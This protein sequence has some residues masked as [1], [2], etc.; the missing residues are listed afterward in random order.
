MG[1]SKA[2]MQANPP[3]LP[4]FLMLQG[5]H[6]PFFDRLNAR[7]RAIG[8]RTCRIGFNLGDRAFWTDPKSFTRYF[9][10]LEDWPDYLTDL[11]ETN[12]ITD[13]VLYGD[14]RPVHK[15]AIEIATERGIPVHVFEEGY[16]R[17]YWITYERGGSNGH[18]RLAEMTIAEMQ[19]TLEAVR[20][21]AIVPPAKWGDMSAHV[22]YGAIYHAFV[23]AGLGRYRAIPSHRGITVRR[24]F[25]LYLQRLGLMP[26]HWVR[27][28]IAT[29]R[30]RDGGFP[31]HLVLLQLA[32][33]ANFLHHGPFH[34]MEDFLE[35]VIHG[36][37]AGAPANHHLVFKAHP[38]E[39][40]RDQI[41]ANVKRL[42]AVYDISARVHYVGGGKL[43][44]VLDPAESAV[45][46]NSTAAQQVLWRGL[47][48]KAFGA[49][50]YAKPELVS[51]QPIAGFFANPKRPDAG[52]YRD[53]HHYLLETS[54]IPGGFYSTRGRA[55][56]LRRI[57]DM[58]LS[59]TDPYDAL[60][61]QKATDRQHIRALAG[62]GDG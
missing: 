58:M 38:L 39:D 30:I 61:E 10:S 34:S 11:I 3:N 1:H 55:Q 25:L 5:P 36:F 62:S 52:A 17:P 32:H 14:T 19:N 2:Q 53:Y 44:H 26:F 13:I 43:A 57:I 50:V 18:S 22:F 24:E 46:V 60:A 41:E 51:D 47:P 33:D 23:L 21:D 42:A 45:T 54:Q 35:T 48:L 31:Y 28:K 59:D 16:L 56:V 12:G 40:G 6:G 29:R 9:G 7:L 27:R 8:A 15:K 4:H 37:A 20:D 49:S